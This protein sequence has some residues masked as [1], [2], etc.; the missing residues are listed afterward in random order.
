[1]SLVYWARLLL[2]SSKQVQDQDYQDQVSRELIQN[3]SETEP[4][5]RLSFQLVCFIQAYQ[6]FLCFFSKCKNTM[7]AL[8]LQPLDQDCVQIESDKCPTPRQVQVQMPES[9]S[10]VLANRIR[11]SFTGQVCVQIQEIGLWCFN[12]S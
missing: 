2:S 6:L 4:S 8:P 5:S 11:I 3:E 10:P 12:C 7:Q 9:P 1:M